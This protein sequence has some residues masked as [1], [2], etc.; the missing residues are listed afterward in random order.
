MYVRLVQADDGIIRIFEVSSMTPDLYSVFSV[1]SWLCAMLY[2]HSS[3][4][5]SFRIGFLL[6]KAVIVSSRSTSQMYL[7]RSQFWRE[8]EG[9]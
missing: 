4:S 7:Y 3:D 1:V 8:S 5:K 2:L 6:T 9:N